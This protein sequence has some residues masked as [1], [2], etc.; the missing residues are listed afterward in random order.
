VPA[1]LIVEVEH[2]S[3]IGGERLGRADILDP[4]PFPQAT[5]PAE[6]GEPAVRRDAGARQDHDALDVGHVPII[7]SADGKA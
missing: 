3:P 2:Q 7:M 4:M 5:R 1:A 6:G